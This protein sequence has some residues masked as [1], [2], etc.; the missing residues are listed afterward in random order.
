MFRIGSMGETPVE[1]MVEGCKRMID[2][3]RELGHDLPD[4]NVETY[5][6]D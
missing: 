4:V 6:S 3:F 5:F 2:C 1:E